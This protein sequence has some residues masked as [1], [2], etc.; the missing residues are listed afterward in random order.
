[1][2]ATPVVDTSSQTPVEEQSPIESNIVTESEV[3]PVVATPIEETSS[4]KI[5]PSSI[6]E[7]PVE[8]A[9]PELAIPIELEMPVPPVVENNS[10]EGV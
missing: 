4:S 3:I 1:M 10:T 7:I 6:E 8:P 5:I 9:S 2:D